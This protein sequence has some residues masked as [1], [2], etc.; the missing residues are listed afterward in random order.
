MI[1]TDI[2]KRIISDQETIILALRSMN[3]SRADKV[4]SKAMDTAVGLMVL[5]GMLNDEKDR[6]QSK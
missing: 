5:E 1:S 2:L 3:D 6:T 4:A